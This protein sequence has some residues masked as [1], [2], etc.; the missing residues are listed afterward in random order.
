MDQDDDRPVLDAESPE[1]EI[2]LVPG[3]DAR[4]LVGDT[5]PGARKQPKVAAVTSFATRFGI[6]GI[7]EEPMGPGLEPIGIPEAR[8]MAP[9]VEQCLLRGVLGEVRVTQDPA[10]HRVQRVTDAFDQLVERLF[11]AAHRQLD[12]LTHPITH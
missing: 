7:H 3:G 12:E 4:C 11:V 10:R 8:K 6:A 2:E 1:G 5:V 9:R